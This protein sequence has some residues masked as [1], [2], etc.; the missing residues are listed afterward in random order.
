LK[1]PEPSQELASQLV[2]NAATWQRILGVDASALT[3]FDRLTALGVGWAALQRGT[4]NA[5]KL[6]YAELMVLGLLRSAE[7]HHRL[8]PTDLRR[9]VQQSSAGMTRILDKLEADGHLRREDLEGDR[10]RVDV[11]LTPSGSALAERAV[12]D[13]LAVE[14]RVIDPLTSEDRAEIARALDALLAV[15]AAHAR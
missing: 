11:V 1:R 15:L 6:N 9:S 4:L 5:L 8:S 2:A 13:L 7:P 3:L 10:R 14:S 12:A